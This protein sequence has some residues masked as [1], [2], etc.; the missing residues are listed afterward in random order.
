MRMTD[1]Q[2]VPPSPQAKAN[3]IQAPMPAIVIRGLP[4][5][6]KT[7]LA[8]RV[9]EMLRARGTTVLHLNADAIRA[10]LNSDLGFDPQSRYENARRIG[11]VVK[12]VLDN[13][14]V[15]VVD[16]VM[17]TIETLN[18][19]RLGIQGGPFVLWRLNR[20]AGFQ[21]RFADTTAMYAN[22]FGTDLNFALPKLDEAASFVI[23]NSVFS[24][25][26]RG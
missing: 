15:P 24:Q 18:S 20:E 13:G 4:N 25:V 1:N 7:T 22:T 10:T 21:S 12:L 17:P 14:I 19:F 3:T 9:V 2:P 16:F 26:S 5:S 6:G 8:N 11:S 23:A